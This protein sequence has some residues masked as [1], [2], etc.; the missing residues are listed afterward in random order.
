METTNIT[1]VILLFGEGTVRYNN[2]AIIICIYNLPF[3]L[4]IFMHVVLFGFSDIGK[5]FF[6]INH[7]NQLR[8]KLT[9]TLF[10]QIDE[11][12]FL[13]Y[14]LMSA[15]ISLS[16]SNINSRKRAYFLSN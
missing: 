2:V 3:L 7:D 4:A 6:F 5:V 1:K 12:K 14:V 10:Y 16:K 11:S 15:I 13:P 8:S 9:A